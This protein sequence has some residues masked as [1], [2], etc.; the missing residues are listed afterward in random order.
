[1][2]GLDQLNPDSPVIQQVRTMLRDVDW[3]DCRFVVSGRPY[4]IRP[5]W[6]DLF[7]SGEG[8]QIVAL[9]EFSEQHHGCPLFRAFQLSSDEPVQQLRFPSV[10][11]S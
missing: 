5:L 11:G 9:D 3:R 2:D 1:L 10:Q 7:E 6:Q 4:A 8:W